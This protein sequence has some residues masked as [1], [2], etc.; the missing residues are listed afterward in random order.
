M[1]ILQPPLTCVT[2]ISTIDVIGALGS[3]SSYIIYERPLINT[4]GENQNITN[5]TSF[6][7]KYKLFQGHTLTL[8]HIR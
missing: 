8:T 4:V 7:R 5:N 1:D 3:L 6:F 2:Y